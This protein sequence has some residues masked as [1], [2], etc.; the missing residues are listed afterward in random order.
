MLS[1]PLV[2]FQ[3][4]VVAPL[5]NIF[6]ASEVPVP[7]V[8]PLKVYDKVAAPQLLLVAL[9]SV[10]ETVYLHVAPAILVNGLPEGQVTLGP[11]DVTVSVLNADLGA[12]QPVVTV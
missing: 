9:N 5:F 7:V 4:M 1:E 10:P 11:E 6:P 8:A 2:A 3:V 12:L